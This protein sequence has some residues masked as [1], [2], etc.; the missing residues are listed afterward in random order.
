MKLVAVVLNWNGGDDTTRALASLAGIE[1]ICVDNGS[2]DG[3]DIEVERRFPEVELLRTGANLGFAGGNNAGIRRALERGAEWVLLVNNDA[4]AEPGIADAL[5]RAAAAR[6]DAGILAC[7]V[8]FEDGG[9]VMYAGASFNAWLGY[10]GRRVGYGKSDRYT[11]LRDVGRADGAAMAISRNAL[12]RAGELDES[13][14]AYVE[15]VDYSLRVRAAGLAVVFVPDAVVRHKGSASTGGRA[16]TTNLYY[17]T[18]NTIAVAERNRPL[19]PGVRALRRAVVVG[20]HLL[21]ATQ[22]PARGAAMRAVLG[23]WRDARAARL[24]QRSS[25]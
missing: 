14:F 6:P 20:T 10:S 8:L 19:P 2:T 11:N 18:R 23:G 1:T 17:S 22:H 5:A 24:G 15:D 3:S 13:L 4:V 7:K 21:Q 16:S 9:S 12:E 25:R